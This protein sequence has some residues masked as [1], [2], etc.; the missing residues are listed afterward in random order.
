MS[1]V[2]GLPLNV[3]IR[4]LCG[5]IETDPS[6][7]GCCREKAPGKTALDREHHLQQCSNAALEVDGG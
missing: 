1:V 7:H 4:A 6:V 2:M 3:L 5:H